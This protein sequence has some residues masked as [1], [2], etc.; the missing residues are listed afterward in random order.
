MKK[1][2]LLGLTGLTLLSGENPLLNDLQPEVINQLNNI[3]EEVGMNELDKKIIRDFYEEIKYTNIVTSLSMYNLV[4]FKLIKNKSTD[5]YKVSYE[6]ESEFKKISLLFSVDYE[7]KNI[8][9]ILPI[10]YNTETGELDSY[11]IVSKV[12]ELK[13][14]TVDRVFPKS[15]RVVLNNPLNPKVKKLFS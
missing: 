12:K 4:S 15:T 14:V 3:S 9:R 7:D 13:E 8:K 5:K 6:L 11:N 2:L 1:K 10:F